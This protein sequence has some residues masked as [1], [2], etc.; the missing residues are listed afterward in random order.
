VNTL[1]AAPAHHQQRF[2]NE[3]VRVTAQGIFDNRAESQSAPDN[4]R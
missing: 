2:E 3:P 4:W 1:L